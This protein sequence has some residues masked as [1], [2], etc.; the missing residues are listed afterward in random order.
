MV[1][2]LNAGLTPPTDGRITVAGSTGAALAFTSNTAFSNSNADVVVTT[3]AV[4][5]PAVAASFYTTA[6]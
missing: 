3:G 2:A 1:A 6:R 4:V 5:A